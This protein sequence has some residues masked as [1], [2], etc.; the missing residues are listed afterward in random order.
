MPEMPTLGNHVG[1][2]VWLRYLGF[3]RDAQLPW[4]VKDAIRVSWEVLTGP[5]AGER[6]EDTQLSNVILV[7]QF[8]DEQAPTDRF[9]R[10]AAQPGRQASPAIYLGNP[11]PGDEVT[12]N[13]WLARQGG[14][15]QQPIPG[16]QP[17]PAPQTQQPPSG[18]TGQPA[19]GQPPYGQPSQQPQQAPW[20]PPQQQ[21]PPANGQPPA[22]PAGMPPT[23]PPP[24]HDDI[25]F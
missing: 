6:V 24:A 10:V 5:N 2:L 22:A 16:P 25:P 3:E 15:P 1:E 20:Y 21:A 18:Y 13:A 11:A 23:A 4:G 19:Y 14:Q 17:Q 12:I 7:R 9:G 8:K